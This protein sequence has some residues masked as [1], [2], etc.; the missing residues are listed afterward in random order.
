MQLDTENHSAL[1]YFKTILLL[2][3][4]FKVLA[5]SLI[6]QFSARLCCILKESEEIIFVCLTS[7]FCAR[8]QCK[9]KGKRTL[10]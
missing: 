8:L 4:A 9:L 1:T 3:A 7:R 2:P 5:V 6:A 10:L